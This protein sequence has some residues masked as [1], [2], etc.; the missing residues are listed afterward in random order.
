MKDLYLNLP[1]KIFLLA[2]KD[3]KI[4]SIIAESEIINKPGWKFIF[5]DKTEIISHDNHLWL[6]YNKAEQLQLHRAKIKN[7]KIPIGSVKST[8]EIVNTLKVGPNNR[9]NHAIPLADPLNL[10]DKK[11][12]IDP[13]ILGIWLGDGAS[14]QG[15]ITSA[16]RSIIKYIEKSGYKVTKKY[17]KKNKKGSISKGV[18]YSFNNLQ[19]DLKEI[20]VFKNKHVPFDYLW[21]SK[22]QRLA[23][24]QG[25]M[26]SDGWA[27]KRGNIDFVNTNKNIID[28]VVFLINSLGEKC[29]VTKGVAKLYGKEISPKWTIRFHSS[30]PMFRLKRKLDRQKLSKNRLN[31]F[32]YIK[33]AIRTEDIK[34]KCIQVSSPDNLYLAGEQL[35]PTH[36]STLL[37]NMAIQMWM[38]DNTFGIPADEFMKGYNVLYFSLE[39][40]YD[41]CFNRMLARLAN[42]PQMNLTKGKLTNAEIDRVDIALSFIE[43]YPYHFQIIDIPRGVTAEQIELR[44]REASLKF[45]PDIVIVDYLG[46]MEDPKSKESSDWLKLGNIAGQLHELGRAYNVVMGT[47]VQLTDI[48]RGQ[49]N[50]S[51]DQQVGVHRVGRSSHVMHHATFGLQIVTRPDEQSFD[52]MEIESIKNRNGPKI[53]ASLGR[54]FANASIIDRPYNVDGSG[55]SINS[56]SSIVDLTSLLNMNN[57]NSQIEDIDNE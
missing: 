18:T 50:K 25:L 53:R 2:C 40:P 10:P 35:I 1:S 28:A 3:G 32:R 43:E 31:K 20:N 56:A 17:F 29:T 12:L 42:V 16:D 26:D 8:A 34:M 11:L 13:Y 9:N 37:S 41:Q 7:K 19:K 45:Q 21:S 30:L 33:D 6:T 54:N 57:S 51:R 49:N 14:S 23:L 36:N 52:D 48:K 27:G 46:L 22:D 24:L 55:N 5:N 47:A 15:R 4:Y 38:Q 39:M 44:Y